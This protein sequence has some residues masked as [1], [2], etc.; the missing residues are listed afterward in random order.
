MGYAGMTER[1]CAVKALMDPI[2]PFA[3]RTI[4]VFPPVAVQYRKVTRLLFVLRSCSFFDSIVS[5]V[6]RFRLLT[7]FLQ[8]AHEKYDVT[9]MATVEVMGCVS[10]MKV[11]VVPIV[12][13]VPA[14]IIPILLARV[15]INAILLCT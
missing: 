10:A 3:Q 1:V 9:I 11:L 2:V 14:I 4:M 12:R 7:F 15:S 13:L 5:N 8:I 6:R